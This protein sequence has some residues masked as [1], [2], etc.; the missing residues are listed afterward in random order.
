M[1]SL[2]SF[3][4]SQFKFFNLILNCIQKKNRGTSSIQLNFLIHQLTVYRGTYVLHLNL[5]ALQRLVL[6]LEVS[7]PQGSELHLNVSALQRP[8][9]LLEVSTPQGPKLIWNVPALQRNVLLLE[10][11]TYTTGA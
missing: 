2:F 6:L 8:V 11:S 9:L 10:V 5:S 3:N 1:S 7:T 4:W